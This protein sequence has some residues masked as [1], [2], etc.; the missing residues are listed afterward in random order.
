MPRAACLPLHRLLPLLFAAGL[1]TTL[2]A[3]DLRFSDPASQPP[4]PTTA[5]GYPRRD[6]DLD[7]LAGFRNPPPGYGEVSFYWWQ[8]D[9]LTRERLRWQL[10]QLKGKSISGLQINYAHSDKGGQKWGLTYPSDPPLFSEPWWEL[11]GWFLKQARQMGAAVSLSDYTLGWPGQGYFTDEIL[12]DTPE[13]HGAVLEHA[14]RDCP[15]AGEFV[16]RFDAA[17]LAVTAVSEDGG[18]RVDL[19]ERVHDG[20]L[21]W[22][23]PAGAWR[24][25]AVRAVS[26]PV[27]IDPMHPASGREMIAKF[28]QRFED[29]NP[30]ESGKG[31][32]FFF[33]DELGFGVRGWLWNR[34]FADEFRKRKGYDVVPELASLFVDMGPKTPKVRLDYSDVMVSLEEENFF[35]PLYEWHRSRGMMFGCDHGGRGLDVTEFGDYFRTQRWMLAP[36]NDQPNLSSDIIKNKVASSIAH[37]YERPRTWL[38]G[39][40]S[41]GWSTSSADVVDATW[42]NFVM[43]HNLLTLHGLYYS[44]RGGWWEW[45]PP[46]NHFR[47][48]YWQHMG[49]F[50]RASERLSYLLSQGR[51]RADVAIVYPVASVEAGMGG[52]E[53]VR[54]AFDLGRHLFNSGID[55]DFMDF[56]S[57]A[58]ARVEGRD[59]RVSGENYRVLVVPSMPAVRHSMLEKAREFHHAGGMVVAMGAMPEA[60][61]RLGSGDPEVSSIIREIF[62]PDRRLHTSAEVEALVNAAFPRDFVCPKAAKSP[63]V[64]HRKVGPRD[65]YMVYGA[66]RDCV[67]AFRASGHVELWNP[68]TGET[69]PLRA[70]SQDAGITRLRMPL[71]ETEAQLIVFSPGQAR[72]EAD[73]PLA[74]ATRIAIESA[75]EFELKPT[76]DN[77][78]GDYRQ[79]A[80]NT[81]IGAEARRFRYVDESAWNANGQDPSL[82]DTSWRT[83]TYSYG[84]RFWKLGPFPADA[85]MAALEGVLA[86]TTN[87]DDRAPVEFAGRRYTWTPYEYSTRWGVEGDAGHQGYHGLK[88]EIPDD[89]IALGVPRFESTTTSYKAEPGGSRYYLWTTAAAPR[90]ME[91]RIIAGG[92][93]PTTVWINGAPTASVAKLHSGANPV[94]LRYDKPGRGHFV[95][96]SASSLADWRNKPGV[97]L[98]D[99]RPAVERPAGWY[100]F[101]SAPGL[102]GLTITAHGKVQA[103]AEGEPLAIDA[104]TPRADGAFEYKATLR[105]VS[106]L[107]VQIAIRVEQQRGHYGGAALPEPVMEDCGPGAIALGDWSLID[108]LSSYSGGAWFRKNIELT[109]AQ[110]HGTVALDLGRVVASAEIHV[111][112]TLAATRLAPPWK[113]DISKFVHAGANRI[114]VLVFNTL[115]NHYQTIPTRYRGSALSGL[116]G[117]VRLE[118]K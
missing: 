25:V 78:W 23:P 84:P 6:A 35:R 74:A 104:G 97:V 36:G 8:G 62:P 112:G 41:S 65:V 73:A 107:P 89:F 80:S 52:K 69:R 2:P 58:R 21:R 50:L 27:S 22:T 54:A 79:P 75:W 56:E 92:N 11:F 42:R 14:T 17:P 38:E 48:P 53:A 102:R 81:M 3:G 111:N 95:L 77:R 32:N 15:D 67:C 43:G 30:G 66:P 37:L 60:S 44:T 88:G 94:L 99:T 83:V 40:H 100:R 82:D 4:V 10:D 70:L 113:V 26:K 106:P 90:A 39:Y 51:H 103:W 110:T 29:R 19:L 34:S 116:L 93:A 64:L 55:F 46:C 72:I 13:I 33:S 105:R 98:F 117:P 108:G 85:D 31:L 5:V 24:V 47:M 71:S 7:A 114:E 101:K 91:A 63:Q 12:K 9:P 87:V 61:D 118:V 1:A 109:A 28:F 18:S 59:L 96:D 86:K 45:A 57:L 115:A 20:V 16:W 68:W 76:L 49:E